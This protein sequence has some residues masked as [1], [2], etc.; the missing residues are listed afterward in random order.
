M[1]RYV[2]D[3]SHTEV[4]FSVRHMGIASVKGHF[5]EFTGAFEVQNGKVQSLEAEIDAASVNTREPQRDTHLRSADFFDVENHPRITFKSNKVEELGERR[6]RVIGDLTIR[7]VTRPVTLTLE[8]TEEAKD[9]WG[10]IRFGFEGKG[11]VDRKEFGLKWNTV[12]ETG[13][14]LVGDRVQLLIEGQAIAEG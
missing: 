10:K 6:Y 8:T 9:P 13:G 3:R 12:L 14:F 5:T 2:V 7:G 1:M 4:G 11:E